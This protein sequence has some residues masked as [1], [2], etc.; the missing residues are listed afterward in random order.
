MNALLLP[1]NSQVAIDADVIDAA[2]RA[3]SENSW[4]ALRADIRCQLS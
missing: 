4:R 2:R 3:M 1:G